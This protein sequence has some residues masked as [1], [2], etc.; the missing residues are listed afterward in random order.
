LERFEISEP[1]ADPDA[2]TE[3]VPSNWVLSLGP[4][5]IARLDNDP[6]FPENGILTLDLRGGR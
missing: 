4:L 5:Q 6:N 2:S 3:E 1:S